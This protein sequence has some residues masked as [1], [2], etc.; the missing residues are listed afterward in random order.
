MTSIIIVSRIV[1]PRSGNGAFLRALPQG[2]D[3]F[4][5]RKGRDF[6]KAEGRWD[7]AVGNPPISQSGEAATEVIT[8]EHG[9]RGKESSQVRD[10]AYS[11]YSAV[12]KSSER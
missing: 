11:A 3:W 2:A 8:A 9:I 4:E 1:E 6:L 5:I 12:E 10:S 7:W